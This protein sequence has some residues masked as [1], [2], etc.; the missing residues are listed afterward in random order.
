MS[1]I[2]ADEL[3]KRGVAAA[4]NGPFF[5]DW[6]FATLFGLS[7]QEVAA[8]ATQI[9]PSS[10]ASCELARRAA[11]SA[12]NNLLGYPHGQE[13]LLAQMLSAPPSALE[14]AFRTWRGEN[15]A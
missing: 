11:A 9:G 8:A 14:A 2:P 3:V 10:V 4:A 1:S 6:E 5:P 12:V 7:R 13:T 15:G